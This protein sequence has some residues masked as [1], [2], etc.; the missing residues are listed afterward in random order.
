MSEVLLISGSTRAGSTNAAALRAAAEVAPAGVTTVTWT[1]L[2]S[3]PAFNPDDDGESPPAPVADLR[4]AI[5]A[6]DAVLFCTPEYA[7]ALPG[8]FKNLLDWT[9]G[10]GEMSG[11]PV[12]WINAAPEGRGDKAHDSLA[13]VLGYLD[14]DVI[15]KA[16]GR[17]PVTRDLLG[18]DG[19]VT[20][21]ATRGRLTEVMTT[22]RDHL[23]AGSN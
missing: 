18:A 10:G 8:S 16:T 23:A 13:I 9:V 20:D 14:T 3:L 17:I 15:T 21:P 4:R 1:G 7:G 2:A 12:A 22:I 11:K 19:T 6:A 5:A